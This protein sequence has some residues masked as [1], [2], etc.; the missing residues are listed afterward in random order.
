MDVAGFTGA[1]LALPDAPREQDPPRDQEKA[2]NGCDDSKGTRAGQGQKVQ[3]TREKHNAG[4]KK[5]TG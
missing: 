2:A 1:A 3:A 4:Y 5:P